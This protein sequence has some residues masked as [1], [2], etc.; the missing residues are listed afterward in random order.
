MKVD[1]HDAQ[2]QRI[3]SLEQQLADYQQREQDLFLILENSP[4]KVASLD[5][6][7]QLITVSQSFARCFRLFFSVH[8][9]PGAKFL[10]LLDEDGSSFWRPYLQNTLT[11]KKQVTQIN[12]QAK[13]QHFVYEVTF[14]PIWQEGQVHRILVFCHDITAQ[15]NAEA[16]AR[17]HAVNL[18]RVLQ[19]ASAGS[20]EYHIPTHT[21]TISQEGLNMMGIQGLSELVLSWKEFI[22]QYVYPEDA[23]M[24]QDRI[25]HAILQQGDLSFQDIFEY[26]LVDAQGKIIHLVIRSRY[27]SNAKGVL[28]G[29]VQ[30]ITE[31]KAVQYRLEQQNAQLK[32]VNSELDN[33]VY[34]VSHDLRAPLTSV[35]GLV[36]VMR[37]EKDPTRLLNYLDLQE[38]S[39][40]KLD[41]FIRE[42]IDLSRNARLEPHYEAVDIETVIQEAFTQQSYD[43][44]ARQIG[45][46][47]HVQA[48]TP[49]VTDRSRVTIILNNLISNALR[50]ADL[51]KPNP[52]AIVQIEADAQHISLKVQDNG[53]GIESQYLS[54]IYEMFF[55]ASETHSGSGLGLYIVKETIDKLGGTI[56]VASEF[57]KGTCFTVSIP[58][59]ISD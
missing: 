33:F 28:Y 23:K 59:H 34:S 10:E 5:S 9:Y 30:D 40:Q 45:R 8:V 18:S 43:D 15:R 1:Q 17:E 26:R 7:F 39:V 55:R 4:E 35:L 37:L 52:E 46:Q 16:E 48:S 12:Q 44:R 32:K 14:Q 22:Q 6:S 2:A 25:D 3:Q 50:Y 11:G 27:K 51:N 21:L 41:Y 29:V 42:I 20:W 53:R 47:I 31:Q 56:H 58:N 49:I 57:G 24:L 38:K 36:N 19:I 13:G 54:R